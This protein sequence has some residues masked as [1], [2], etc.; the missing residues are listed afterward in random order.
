MAES[1]RRTRKSAPAAKD[2]PVDTE[3]AKESVGATD[4]LSSGDVASAEAEEASV[5]LADLLDQPVAEL[6]TRQL[7]EALLTSLR[8]SNVGDLSRVHVNSGPPGF[9]NSGGHANFDPKTS[10]PGNVGDLSRVHVNSGPP[11]F[12]NSGGHANFDPK[13]SLPGNVGEVVRLPDGG[14]VTLPAQGRVDMIVRG[15]RVTR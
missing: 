3:G 5:R 15:F 11:G 8:A 4:A 13:T 6:S 9:A 14:V 7:I 2:E 10:L 12:A 1:N